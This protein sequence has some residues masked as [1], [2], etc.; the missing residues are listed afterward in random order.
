[1]TDQHNYVSAT[2]LTFVF[3]YGIL[4]I[5]QFLSMLVHRVT[6]VSHYFARAP[7]RCGRPMYV[8][9]SF[10]TWPKE[11]DLEDTADR[12]AFQQTKHGAR[13]A[14]ERLRKPK[15]RAPLF[16]TPEV[17]ETKPLLS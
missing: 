12:L 15:K 17:D 3:I 1:M 7:Y 16:A 8:G 14:L 5:V 2:G 11:Q 4:F 6:T 13:R 10:K 9:W